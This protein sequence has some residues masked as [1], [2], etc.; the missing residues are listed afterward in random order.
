MSPMGST[1]Q[2]DNADLAQVSSKKRFS[3]LDGRYTPIDDHQIHSGEHDPMSPQIRAKTITRNTD[4]RAFS[5]IK[6]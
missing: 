2:V 6:G 5:F 4:V 3:N 1:A